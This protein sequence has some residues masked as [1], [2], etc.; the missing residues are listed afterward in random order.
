[1]RIAIIGSSAFDSLEYNLNEA[2]IFG[3]N[4]CQIFDIYDTWLIKGG[5]M[6]TITK[7]L[8][9]LGRRYFD[10][11]DV[12][13]FDRIAKRVLAYR[14]DLVIGVY[15]FIHPS[16]VKRIKENGIKI[17]H[18]NPDALTTFEYQQLFVEAYD[19]YFTKDPY[20]VDFMR[21]NMKLN[22]RLYSEAFNVRIHKKPAV[23]KYE[24]EENVGID[25]MT[26]GTM[27]PYRVRMLSELLKHGIDLKVYGVKPHR[28]YNSSIDSAFQ[29]KY[30]SGN[31]KS[32]LLYGTKI[33]FN[34]MHYAEIGSVNNRFFEV[35]GSGAFQLSDYRPV[36]NDL[37]PID[38]Q[39][40]SFR[41]LDE[42]I[43]KVKYYLAHPE[44]RIEIA[45][46]VYAHFIERYT[47]DNLIQYLL[48]NI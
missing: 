4:E 40:V 21:N 29:N 33:V 27:Y 46:K 43:D 45:E 22:A 25:V 36:L 6:L 20:I 9:F 39:L 10:K 26:Y 28:F 8:D 11:Y 38:P 7:T 17:I 1:M 3:G 16:F 18:V 15:R 14:P 23:S 37:L 32:R 19:T 42:G 2:F 41:T 47:Y 30:I 24:C 48:N 35:N 12:E 5:R 44:E 34:Q 13:V 31:E